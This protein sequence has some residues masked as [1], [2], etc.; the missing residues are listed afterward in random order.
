MYDMSTHRHV[1]E[2]DRYI[3]CSSLFTG[4]FGVHVHSCALYMYI[5]F[6]GAYIFNEEVQTCDNMCH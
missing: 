6:A 4:K 2:V 3:H 1:K 5:Y